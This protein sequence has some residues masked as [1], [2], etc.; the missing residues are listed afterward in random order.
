VEHRPVAEE[1]CPDY[2]VYLTTGRVLAQY[3]SG[4]QTRRIAPLHRAA[5]GAF[6]ELHPDLAARLGVSD[7]DEVL[8]TSR[9]GEMR[10]PARITTTIRPDTVFA[11]FH[12]AGAAR[13]NSVTSDALDPVSRM[14]EFKVCAVRVEK[15]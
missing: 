15:A 10:A 13:I 6:L 12:W 1:V 11:P 3:Q 9:R 8:V 5:P 2:P 7:G 14:P 4:A